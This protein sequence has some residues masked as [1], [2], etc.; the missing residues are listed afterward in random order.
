MADLHDYI[1]PALWR[2]MQGEDPS[3][4]DVEEYKRLAEEA[5]QREK[6]ERIRG[7][8]YKRPTTVPVFT[9]EL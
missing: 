4:E 3:P 2:R 5:R 8:S 6:E 1:P 9:K 7:R